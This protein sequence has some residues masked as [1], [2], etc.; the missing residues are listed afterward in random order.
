M[1]VMSAAVIAV[2]VFT[3]SGFLASVTSVVMRMQVHRALYGEQRISPW[4]KR[5]V[6]SLLGTS[7]I[8]NR[9]KQAFPRSWLRAWIWLLMLFML[10]SLSVFAV[11]QLRDRSRNSSMTAPANVP[12]SAV[13][14]G[15]AFIECSVEPAR[16]VNRCRV[17]HADGKL[18]CERDFD[19]QPE[20]RHA[21]AEELKFESFDGKVIHL[22]GGQKL[23]PLMACQAED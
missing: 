15:D 2:G 12:K 10:V 18:W 16:R 17:F 3:A 9:H 21:R 8:L 23:V 20:N 22:H 4:D 1:C 13:H 5:F 11:L 7:G 6:N 14:P 19:L